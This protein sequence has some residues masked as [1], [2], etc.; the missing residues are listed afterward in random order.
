MAERYISID[1][2]KFA[3]KISEY[4]PEYDGIRKFQIRTKVSEGDFRDDA[5]EKTL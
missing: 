2:G 3:S 4:I 5:I 1:S